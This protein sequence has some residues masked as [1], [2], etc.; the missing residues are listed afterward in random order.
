MKG[1]TGDCSSLIKLGFDLTTYDEETGNFSVQ[2]SQ[3][4]ALVIQGVPCH[5]HG[6]TNKPGHKWPFVH[7]EESK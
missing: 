5:E 1:E 2:C 7:F 4:E 6:C 3:C